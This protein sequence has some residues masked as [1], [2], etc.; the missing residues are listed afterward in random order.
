MI[1]IFIDAMVEHRRNGDDRRALRV[2][3]AVMAHRA[4]D[5]PADAHMFLRA[6]YE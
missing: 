4:K 1:M 3:E 6:D 5:Q 2:A